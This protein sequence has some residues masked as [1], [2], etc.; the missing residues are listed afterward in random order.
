M[1]NNRREDEDT[2]QTAQGTNGTAGTTPSAADEVELLRKQLEEEK[3]KAEEYLR[4]LQRTQA[5]FVNY[6]RRAEQEKA[7]HLRYANSA[8]ILKILPVLDD[9][10]RAFAS[11]PRE[12][13]RMTWLDGIALI[14][15]KM[16]FILEQEGV[17]PIET[18]GKDFDPTQ[19]EAVLFEEGADPQ[20]GK[21]V[22]ELQ[23]GY[24]LG[25]RVIRPALVKVGQMPE[26]ASDDKGAG[27]NG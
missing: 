10:D 13:Q 17:T 16:R 18:L 9:F 14:E 3:T 23:K 4:H 21:V 20:H 27:G 19:H 12:F 7:E 11:I 26:E 2:K 1:F 6:K 25:D 15:R 24:K 22:A 8:L 5:D